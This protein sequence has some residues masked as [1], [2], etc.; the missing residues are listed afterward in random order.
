MTDFNRNWAKKYN[1]QLAGRPDRPE[2]LG[3]LVRLMEC[4]PGRARG[5]QAPSV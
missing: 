4:A 1:I 2:K 5:A 3:G